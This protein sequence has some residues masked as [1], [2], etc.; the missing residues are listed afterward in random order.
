MARNLHKALRLRRTRRHARVRA[1]VRGSGMR[2]RLSVFR[3]AKHLFIQLI[4]DS[5]GVT[6]LSLH[7]RHLLLE[8]HGTLKESHA[9]AKSDEGKAQSERRNEAI[10][11]AMGKLLALRAK[12]KGIEKVIFDRGAYAY[13]GRVRAVAQGARAGGLKF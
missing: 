12:E 1:K 2:P 3:S 9:T 11:Y 10:A 4:D 7:D 5:S 6:L 13:H 8:H